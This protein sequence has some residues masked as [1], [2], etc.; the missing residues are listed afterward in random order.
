ME[1][2]EAQR[3]A[4]RLREA[5]A[6]WRG[7]LLAGAGGS[8]VDAAATALEEQRLTAAEQFYELCIDA[9]EAAEITGEL[10]VLVEEHPLRETLRSRLMLALYRSGQQASALDEFA[11]V[12]AHLADELGIDPGAALTRLHERILRQ[13]PSLSRPKRSAPRASQQAAR[14]SHALPFDVPDFSGRSFELEWI[15]DA[16]GRA[17]EGAS[18]VLALDG[19]GGGGKTALAVRAAHQLA[20]QYPHGSLFIDL[21]GFTPGQT[22]LDVFRAQGDL[23]AAAGIPSEEIPMV[24]AG[25]A[26]RWQSY[27]RGRRMVLVL[28]NAASSE[29]V[30]ALIR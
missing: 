4:A 11:R 21:H 19:M 25:R 26:A 1:A 2:G 28:D 8:V 14:P 20:E 18:R 22:P 24:P 15:S 27:M 12:R 17:P 29:P 7:P 10:R 9:G 3:A 16:A 5:L 13:D 30:R 23:L 6:L